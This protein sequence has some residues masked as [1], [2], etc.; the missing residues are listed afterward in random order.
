[1]TPSRAA[2][3]AGPIRSPNF[4]S[5]SESD[6][7]PPKRPLFRKALATLDL[8][9]SP[10]K[11]SENAQQ[12]EQQSNRAESQSHSESSHARSSSKAAKSESREKRESRAD[13]WREEKEFEP[14]PIPVQV[15][16]PLPPIDSTEA[17]QRALATAASQLIASETLLARSG[18]ARTRG[19]IDFQGRKPG[20]LAFTME[21]KLKKRDKRT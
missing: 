7:E 13:E 16:L 9:P 20:K 18:S 5:D 15:A 4:D 2:A 3:L 21:M 8:P 10:F 12:T 14:E 6:E 1:M 17:L 11:P 19:E